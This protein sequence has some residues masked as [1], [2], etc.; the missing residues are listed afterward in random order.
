MVEATRVLVLKEPGDME[1]VADAAPPDTFHDSVEVTA[2]AVLVGEAEKEMIPGGAVADLNAAMLALIPKL[3]LV[4]L[5]I[6]S[7]F[8]AKAFIDTR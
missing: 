3:V 1:M 7:G 2:G 6:Q 5:V 4:L 8:S